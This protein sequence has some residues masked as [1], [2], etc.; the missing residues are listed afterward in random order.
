M[1]C[2]TLLIS[3]LK[4]VLIVCH[5]CGLNYS[6]S[7]AG[8]GGVKASLRS[9]VGPWLLKMKLTTP[10]ILGTYIKRRR[11]GFTVVW[12]VPIMETVVEIPFSVV[13]HPL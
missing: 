6:G 1:K 10:L 11:G 4:P 8:L 7:E 9:R 3:E 13:R 2:V 5:T 12:Y